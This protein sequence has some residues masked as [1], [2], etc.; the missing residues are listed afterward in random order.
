MVAARPRRKAHDPGAA[1][2]RPRRELLN[3]R[4]LAEFGTSSSLPLRVFQWKNHH[5]SE[6]LRR[7]GRSADPDIYPDRPSSWNATRTA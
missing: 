4:P 7:Q 5:Q 3:P 1:T 6:K 2:L